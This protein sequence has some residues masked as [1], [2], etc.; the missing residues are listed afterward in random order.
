MASS[1]DW[2]IENRLDFE[3]GLNR[4]AKVTSDFR[5]PFQVIASD[6]YRS[7]RKIFK[8]K[9][10][11]LYAPLG[12]KNP[13]AAKT[14]RAKKAKEK[15]TGHSWAPILYGKSGDLRDSTLGKNHRYS[16]FN[17]DFTSM[18]IGSSVPYGPFLQG[19]TKFMEARPFVFID[20]G[21]ADRSKD[22]SISG[23]RDRWL[24]IINDHILQLITGDVLG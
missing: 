12:G 2:T 6:F 18:E 4:L 20:G 10:A 9:S 16:I 21:P 8:L 23:R 13:S 3:A 14:N 11:G 5:I 15:F 17:L 22:S 1:F 24:N 7:Q 19:G